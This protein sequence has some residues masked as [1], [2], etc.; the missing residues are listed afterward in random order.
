MERDEAYSVRLVVD[1]GSSDLWTIGV[2]H[3]VVLVPG[4]TASKFALL[5]ISAWD[6]IAY[7]RHASW[8]L[9]GAS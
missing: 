4:G 9:W 6:L 5:R 3:N 7:L 2:R 8:L 1:K